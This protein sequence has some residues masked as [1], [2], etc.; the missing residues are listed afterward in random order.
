MLHPGPRKF[1]GRPCC[2]HHTS[3]HC[4]VP[5]PHVAE[6]F[7]LATYLFRDAFAVQLPDTVVGYVGGEVAQRRVL[8]G[9]HVEAGRL[10]RH[11]ERGHDVAV[12]AQVIAEMELAVE[13]FDG[14]VVLGQRLQHHLVV[15]APVL[16]QQYL[17]EPSLADD[18]HDVERLDQVY[19]SIVRVRTEENG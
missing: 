1:K 10:E 3:A 14:R 6:K 16:D 2:T 12:R 8:L 9:E 5:V 19:L 7:R 15:R 17:P 4:A 11:V 18:L 13:V